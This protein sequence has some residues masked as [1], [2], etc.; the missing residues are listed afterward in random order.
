MYVKTRQ[1]RKRHNSRNGEVDFSYVLAVDSY[2]LSSSCNTFRN[3]EPR[4]KSYKH[5]QESVE[6]K[7][8]S[9]NKHVNMSELFNSD[10]KREPIYKNC[11]R[12][13]YY[14]PERSD[15]RAFICFYQLCFGKYKNLF[16]KIFVLVDNIS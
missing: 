5:K 12:G 15:S 9:V 10:C 13:F 8:F 6:G 1:R 14:R 7:R 4:N 2:F 11:K 16:T 3:K